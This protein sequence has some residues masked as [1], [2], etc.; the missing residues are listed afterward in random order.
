MKAYITIAIDKDNKAALLSGP[1]VPC[2]EQV[3][4]IKQMKVDGIDNNYERVELWTGSQ[5]R[6]IKATQT[7]DYRL[8]VKKTQAKQ[9]KDAEKALKDAEKGEQA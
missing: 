4:A 7:K 8:K 3:K 6:I 2:G 5:G 9:L 1:D